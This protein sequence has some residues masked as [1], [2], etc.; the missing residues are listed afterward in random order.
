MHFNSRRLNLESNKTLG[1]SYEA[2]YAAQNLE[3]EISFYWFIL[4]LADLTGK[5]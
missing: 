1:N 3:I 5:I 2:S 4:L